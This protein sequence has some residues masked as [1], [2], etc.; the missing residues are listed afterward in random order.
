MQNMRPGSS[1]TTR[2]GFETI[3]DLHRQTMPSEAEMLK[4][5]EQMKNYNFRWNSDIYELFDDEDDF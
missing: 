5:Q 4:R 1:I 2:L 3:L